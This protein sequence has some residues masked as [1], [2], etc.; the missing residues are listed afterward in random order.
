MLVEINTTH[1][2]HLA[3]AHCL[4]QKPIR[5]R[6]GDM[7]LEQLCRLLDQ[8]AGYMA[9]R[10]PG[11]EAEIQIIG[12]EPT[13]L[14]RTYLE[15]A[16]GCAREVF[17]EAG[18]PLNLGLATNLLGRAATEIACAELFD[19]VY[20]S[21]DP[22]IRFRDRAAEDAWK[23][24][25]RK[26]LEG[27]AQ[28]TVSV[29]ITRP[30]VARHPAWALLDRLLDLGVTRVYLGHFVPVGD[31]AARS[32][33]LMPSLHAT[34]TYMIASGE[35]L[36]AHRDVVDG[37]L[38]SPVY[39]ALEAAE[40]R[41]PTDAL[42]CPVRHG[43]LTIGPDGGVLSCVCDGWDTAGRHG[44]VFADGF[45]AVFDSP[46]FRRRVGEALRR[47]RECAVCGYYPTCQ[48]GCESMLR[49]RGDQAECHGFR[50]LY[51]WAEAVAE[52]KCAA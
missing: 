25:V 28:V 32:E 17:A 47:P 40:Q 49:V 22:E 21:Y 43:A 24:N 5:Q 50:S 26:A 15:E 27:G 51:A 42:A 41:R 10:R 19:H 44:N 1:R 31:G 33:Q 34:A 3:C 11:E 13:L 35:W 9:T 46:G 38:V 4:V 37:L 16:V 12:G 14:G 39:G 20:T 23:A 29:T 2:C 36:L 52:R 45:A 8:I 18:V 6:S 7:K 48:G 30:V